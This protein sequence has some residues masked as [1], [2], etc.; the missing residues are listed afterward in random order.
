MLLNRVMAFL[1]QI[2]ASL[3]A[4][5]TQARLYLYRSVGLSPKIHKAMPF[6]LAWLATLVLAVFT[7]PDVW[8]WRPEVFILGGQMGFLLASGLVIHRLYRLAVPLHWEKRDFQAELARADIF[9]HRSDLRTASTVVL[10]ST[11]INILMIGAM[12]LM[13]P[14]FALAFATLLVWIVAL[15]MVL[16]VVSADPPSP[17]GGDMKLIPQGA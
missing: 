9:R 8:G 11:S 13:T 7:T 17:E 15:V 10:T 6:A 1:E 16:Y 14:I 2:D 3:I 4:G 12:G 5:S